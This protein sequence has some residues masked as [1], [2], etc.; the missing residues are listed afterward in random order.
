M[1]CLWITLRVGWSWVPDGVDLCLM[2]N[3]HTIIFQQTRGQRSGSSVWLAG[4]FVFL[5]AQMATFYKY[6]SM[7]TT[8]AVI[9]QL[10]AS[11]VHRNLPSVDFIPLFILFFEANFLHSSFTPICLALKCTG[12]NQETLGFVCMTYLYKS[13]IC[14]KMLN[15]EYSVKEIQFS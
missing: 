8:C 7:D 14:I 5:V 9:D 10:S 6:C 13:H 11:Q 12:Q 15:H 1:S 4:S 3:L 2:L